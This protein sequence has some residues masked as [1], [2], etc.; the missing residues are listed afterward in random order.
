[1]NMEL[2][3]AI[4]KMEH[5]LI[6]EKCKYRYVEHTE[7]RECEHNYAQGNTGEMREVDEI[8]LNAMKTRR[9][10]EEYVFAM[11]L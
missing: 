7:C 10:L 5:R 9:K 6:C 11:G 1:M 4:E 2:V 8:A 3:E